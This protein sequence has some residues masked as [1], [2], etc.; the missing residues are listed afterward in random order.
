MKF[1]FTEWCMSITILIVPIKCAHSTN[2]VPYVP[3]AFM[4]VVYCWSYPLYDPE[5]LRDC[6][7]HSISW[8]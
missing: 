7:N 8:Q 5:V 6:H 1:C 3:N 4:V 2:F